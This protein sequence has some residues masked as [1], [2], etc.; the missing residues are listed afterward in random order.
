MPEEPQVYSAKKINL[1]PGTQ[2]ENGESSQDQLFLSQKGAVSD[3]SRPN[4]KVFD[5]DE[6]KEKRDKRHQAIQQAESL[7]SGSQPSGNATLQSILNQNIQLNSARSRGTV[8]SNLSALLFS[9][10]SG[11]SRKS[12]RSG[13]SHHRSFYGEEVNQVE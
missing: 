1:F 11:R 6:S 3:P 13:A 10:K 8:D 9:G 5:F 4:C 12:G 2:P 7:L